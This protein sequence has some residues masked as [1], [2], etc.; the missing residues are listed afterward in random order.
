MLVA[1]VSM[2]VVSYVLVGVGPRTIGRQ[3]PY[4]VGLIAAG[5]VRVLGL[6]LGPLSRLLITLGNLITPGPR[7]PVRP[8]LLRGGAARAGRPGR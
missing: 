1:S 3:H 4:T 8:V 6:V 2:V 7:L 5:P